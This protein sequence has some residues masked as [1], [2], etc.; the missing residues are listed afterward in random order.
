[1]VTAVCPGATATEFSQR[2]DVGGSRAATFRLSQRGIRRA[3][4]TAARLAAPGITTARPARWLYEEARPHGVVV[5]AVCPGATATEF[6]Q[7]AD[8]G[9]AKRF[10]GNAP[11]A[12]P[13]PSG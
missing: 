12:V 11:A 3:A 4:I 13:R 9:G 7:R 1:V 5:T 8:V 6:S 2:A 10:T